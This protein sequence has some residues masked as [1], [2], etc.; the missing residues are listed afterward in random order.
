MQLGSFHGAGLLQ[1]ASEWHNQHACADQAI[2]PCVQHE[3]VYICTCAALCLARGCILNHLC[4]HQVHSYVH[5]CALLSMCVLINWYMCRMCKC[6]RAFVHCGQHMCA[7]HW[8]STRPSAARNLPLFLHPA[9]CK[10][11]S[12]LVPLASDRALD[13]VFALCP[14][15]YAYAL[16]LCPKDCSLHM[17]SWRPL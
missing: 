3:H 8:H 7:D 14:I 17:P 10:R 16:C 2:R 12:E 13:M 1:I 4:V 5:L 11:S 9:L 15:P 6:I